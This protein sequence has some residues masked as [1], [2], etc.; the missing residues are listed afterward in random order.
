L[1]FLVSCSGWV[2][3]LGAVIVVGT[4]LAVPLALRPGVYH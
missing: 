3:P 2:L 4:A 1:S